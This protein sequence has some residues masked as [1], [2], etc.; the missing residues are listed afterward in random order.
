VR[1]GAL[2]TDEYAVTP[3]LSRGAERVCGNK[4]TQKRTWRVTERRAVD[5]RR[6][7]LKKGGC[8]KT[9]ERGV[10][11][12]TTY[13]GQLTREQS[14]PLAKKKGWFLAGLK[15]QKRK[16]AERDLATKL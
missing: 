13:V 2:M 10:P 3:I 11:R 8:R 4:K 12:K 14:A 1:N 6:G 15:L 9:Y 7:G 5:E 16:D